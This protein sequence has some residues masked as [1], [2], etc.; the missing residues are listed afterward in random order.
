[1]LSS[2]SNSLILSVYICVF[3]PNKSIIQTELICCYVPKNVNVFDMPLG[4]PVDQ[5]ETQA[6]NQG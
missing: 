6:G 4:G 5:G 1:M 3:P 2:S